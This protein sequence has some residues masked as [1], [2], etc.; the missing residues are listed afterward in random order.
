MGDAPAGCVKTEVS[1][2]VSICGNKKTTTT[3]TKYTMANGS[4][5]TCT[6]TQIEQTS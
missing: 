3:E 1:T 2:S 5:Q 6:Q 4:T